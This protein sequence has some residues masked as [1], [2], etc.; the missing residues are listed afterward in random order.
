MDLRTDAFERWEASA[1]AWVR[2][3]ARGDRNR[4]ELLDAHMLELAGEV[5]GRDVLD[6]GSGEGRFCRML[7][8]RGARCVEL[9]PSVGMLRAS[10]GEK[11]VRGSASESPFRDKSFDL[12]IAYLVL[13]DIEDFRG[14][15]AEA[16]RVL[17]PG[18]NLLVANLNPFATTRPDPWRRDEAGR[19]IHM[20]VD[21]YLDERPNFVEWSGISVINWHRPLEAWMTAFLD[22][23]FDLRAY[24]EPKAVDAI[25]ERIPTFNVMLWSRR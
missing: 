13:I 8:S 14:A 3:I 10:T 9:E 18:G 5:S 17:R 24:R 2:G 7:E 23:G 6:V 19:P 20:I 12:A 21:D 4:T 16:H 15:I 22:V 1:D 11:R 25:G